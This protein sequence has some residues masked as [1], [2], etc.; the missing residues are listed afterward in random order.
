MQRS[1][2]ISKTVLQWKTKLTLL[3]IALFTMYNCYGFEVQPMTVCGNKA[4][5]GKVVKVTLVDKNRVLTAKLDTGASMASLTASDITII[6]KPNQNWVRF[7]LILP[8]TKEKIIFEEPLIRMTHILKREEEVK[9]TSRQYSTRPVIKLKIKLNNKTETIL[10]NL[11]DRRQFQY[12]LLIGSE[13][14]KK[15]NVLVDVNQ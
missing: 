2:Q 14:L 4:V 3:L 8:K 12:P 6:K 7:W 9:N 1:S 10:V 15:F 11:I 13:A 5:L